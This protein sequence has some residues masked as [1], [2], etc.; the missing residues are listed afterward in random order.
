MIRYAIQG[1][2]NL[3]EAQQVR[4]FKG[5]KQKFASKTQVLWSGVLNDCR[6]YSED[7]IGVARS[8]LSR[9]RILGFPGSTLFLVGLDL[10]DLTPYEVTEE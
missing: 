10:N 6:L 4:W 8:D 7:E 9:L 2:T 1:F 3:T 5:F